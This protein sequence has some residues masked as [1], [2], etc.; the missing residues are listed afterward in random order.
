VAEL[1]LGKYSRKF[2]DTSKVL[3]DLDC[4]KVDGRLYVS[5]ED[6]QGYLGR[7]VVGVEKELGRTATLLEVA[8]P[9]RDSDRVVD[10]CDKV[11]E[12]SGFGNALVMLGNL[13]EQLMAT[14]DKK[15]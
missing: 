13:M 12:V 5:M 7:L 4:T 9:N 8:D 3:A 15:R 6:L 2:M 1:E 10:L 14:I 11:A